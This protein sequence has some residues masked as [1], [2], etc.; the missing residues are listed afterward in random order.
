MPKNKL[1]GYFFKSFRRD[2]GSNLMVVGTAANAANTQAN[3]K[4]KF[5]KSTIAPRQNGQNFRLGS[6][7][8]MARATT[9]P[10][11]RKPDHHH[12]DVD[13]IMYGRASVSR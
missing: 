6:G 5:V 9:L 12:R 8:P 11:P 7:S 10:W 1:N 2:I 3:A 4:L 13:I